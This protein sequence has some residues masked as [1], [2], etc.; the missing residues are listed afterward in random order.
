MQYQSLSERGVISVSG[1][2]RLAFLATTTTATMPRH[3]NGQ[4][5][6][7]ALLTPQGKFLHDFFLMPNGDELWIDC[8]RERMDDLLKRLAMY[9]LRAKVQVEPTDRQVMAVWN[10]Q[11]SGL[12]IEDSGLCVKDPRLLQ[13]EYRI[14]GDIKKIETSLAAQGATKGDYDSFRLSLGVPDGSRDMIVD[15]S[16]LLEW[17]IDQ[18][19][20]VDFQ[21]GCFIGQEVTARS[22]YRAQ[23]KKY[24]H[25]VKADAALPPAGTSIAAGGVAIGEMRSSK[26][27]MGLAIVRAEELAKARQEG[28][29]VTAGDVAVALSLPQWFTPV[30]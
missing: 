24:I 25:Q 12:R 10:V 9:K 6:Y 4:A 5:A 17:G 20:G 16:L 2:D 13:L 29:P 8:E 23:L 7:G 11:D 18:L 28:L 14:I 19:G 3:E 21:K 26:N 30:S 1:A 22:K 15:K 27:K